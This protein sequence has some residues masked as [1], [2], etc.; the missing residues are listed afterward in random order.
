MPARARGMPSR[1]PIAMSMQTVSTKIGPAGM[2]ASNAG[3]G[4]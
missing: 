1:F 3:N 4:P 2:A